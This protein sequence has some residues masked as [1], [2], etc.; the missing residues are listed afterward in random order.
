MNRISRH[1]SVTLDQTFERDNSRSLHLCYYVKKSTVESPVLILSRAI[2]TPEDET[3]QFS[4][5]TYYHNATSSP[6]IDDF[7]SEYVIRRNVSCLSR[8]ERLNE[9]N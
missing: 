4:D 1:V 9:N 7:M 2:I 6:A 5:L 8:S 3:F